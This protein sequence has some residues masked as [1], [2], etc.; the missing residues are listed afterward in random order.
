M[1]TKQ[2]AY[3]AALDRINNDL[4]RAQSIINKAM[5]EFNQMEADLGPT[6]QFADE[7]QTTVHEG[8]NDAAI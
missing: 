8:D 2:E 3:N 6:E 7:S 5:A 4:S 1:T